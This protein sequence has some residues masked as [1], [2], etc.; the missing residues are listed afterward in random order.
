MSQ[1]YEAAFVNKTIV[2]FQKGNRESSFEKLKEFVNNNSEDETARYNFALMCEQLNYTDLAKDH[3]ETI[4]KKNSV[5]WKSKFNL[6]L[7]YLNKKNYEQAL[8]LVNDVLKI[9]PNYQPALRDKAV[10]L[11]YLKRAD[12]GLPFIEKSLTAITLASSKV[13][14]GIEFSNSPL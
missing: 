11:Y 14:V 13:K 6:Y 5:H 8:Q 9:K 4:L 3:Y 10:I 2:D 7:I 1:S 12:E